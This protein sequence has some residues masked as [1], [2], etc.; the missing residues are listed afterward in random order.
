LISRDRGGHLARGG[1]EEA[2]DSEPRNRDVRGALAGRRV[3]V[4]GTASGEHARHRHWLA[5]LGAGR[6]SEQDHTLP[7]ALPRPRPNST[8]SVNRSSASRESCGELRDKLG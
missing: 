4:W 8:T 1:R 6:A 3:C 2:I 5:K 7:V